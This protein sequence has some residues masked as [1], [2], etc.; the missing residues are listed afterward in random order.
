[1]HRY[2][3]S[4]RLLTALMVLGVLARPMTASAAWGDETSWKSS[5]AN[6]NW[7][8]DHWYNVTQGW[9]NHNPN[10]EGGRD[11]VF[12]N[13]NQL[14]MNN[15]FTGGGASRWRIRFLSGASSGR[16]IG[17]S[18]ANTF[19]DN[20][21]QIPKIENSSAAT[22]T[23]NFPMVVGYSG[24]MEINP[25]SGGLT[26]GGTINNGGYTINVWGDNGH[27]L[28]L[29]NVIS[30]GGKLILKQNSI[31]SINAAQTYT[32]NTEIDKGEIWIG[33][34]GDIASGSAIYVGNGA[35]TAN[36]TK[37]FINNASGGK[38]FARTIN[39][40]A[41]NGT[42]S[43]RE[44][45]ALNSSGVNTF[46][47]NI[48][49]STGADDRTLTLYAPT[50]GTVDFT[51]VISGD[52]RVIKRAAGTVRLANANSYTGNTEIDAGALHI[53]QGGSIAG[54]TVYVGNGGTTGTAA[55]FLI[56]DADGG[57]AVARTIQINPGNGNQG[58]R[59]IGG[60]NT[61]GINTF[62]GAIQRDTDG[63]NE[64]VTLT[65][66]AGGIVEYTGV[67]S[68]DDAVW[69]T[70][71]GITRF[72]GSAKSYTGSTTI[73]GNSTL[74]LNAANLVNDSVNVFIDSGSTFDLNGNNETVNSVSGAGNV[75]LGA[76]QLIVDHATDRTLSGIISGTG[77]FVKKGTS[78]L[79]LSGA[80]TYNGQ[81]YVVGG[82]LRFNVN[83]NA[84]FSNTLNLGET[85]GSESATLALGADGVTLTN[86][87]L[88][89]AGSS[90]V[91]TI[92]ALN[93]TGTAIL[94][95]GIT[96]ANPIT[97]SANAGGALTVS[98]PIANSGNDLTTTTTGSISLNA[99]VGGGGKLIKQGSGTLTLAGANSY[100]GHT[101]IDLGTLVVGSGGDIAD[102]STTYIGNGIS[103][104]N[105]ALELAANGVDL[106][107]TVQVNPDP[108]AG[109]RT[110]ASTAA[111]GGT[112]ISGLVRLSRNVSINANSGSTLTL[113]GGLKMDYSGNNDAT[114]NGNVVLGGAIDVTSGASEINYTGGGTL[115]ISGD[116]SGEPYMLNIAGGTVF[117]NH[118]NALGSATS[119]PDKI[120]FSSGAS[121]LRVGTTITHNSMGMKLA[122]VSPTF[123]VDG[124]ATFTVGGALDKTSGTVVIDK[125][126][127]GDLRL[128]GTPSANN[129]D[130]TVSA[131]T[132]S[133][134]GIGGALTVAGG[135]RIAPGTSPGTMDAGDTAW[136]AGGEYVWE[137]NDFNGAAGS[138]P[139]WD[140]L[141]VTGTLTINATSGNPFVIRLTS[142]N[143][144]V[145]GNAANFN[146]AQPY[147]LTIASAS[148]AVSG[149]VADRFSLDLSGFANAL[150]SGQWS[151]AGSANSVSL[152]FTPTTSTTTTSTTTTSSTTTTTTTTSSSTTT[153]TDSTSTTT[154]STTIDTTTTTTTTTESTSS[155]TTTT[156]TTTTTST[157][158]T[159]TTTTLATTST[160]A[161]PAS[162]LPDVGMRVAQDSGSNYGVAWAGNGGFGFDAW[163][164]ADFQGGGAAGVFLANTGDHGDLNH[165]W[166]TP[167]FKAWGTF[168]NGAGFNAIVA[169][170]SFAGNAL[171]RAGDT[172]KI[173]MENGSIQAG[174]T[175]GIVL[176]HG[177]VAIDYDSFDDQQRLQFY[178][179]GGDSNYKVIDQSGI[180]DTGVPF[181]FDG[182]DLIFKLTGLNTYEL[183]IYYAA[184]GLLQQTLTGTLAGSGTIDSVALFNRDVELANVYF[185]KMTI[186]DVDTL[187]T[188]L[189]FR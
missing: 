98:A 38:T 188:M 24:G 139:G 149:F 156:T 84:N 56:T 112:A 187:P 31:I 120:N 168:A 33:N 147:T 138:D 82:S 37:L 89:R 78:T 124:G 151:V 45:G 141:N 164:F 152:V 159:T 11:L 54:G 163:T 74:R 100:T 178:F 79:T 66:A 95:G 15:D 72:G 18:T 127:A 180:V 92:A 41:G 161:S 61:S 184:S 76:G 63:D 26:L 160:T 153:T 170:R 119:Y 129:V 133:G 55:E 169:F 93:A 32:G 16:T 186:L 1:M 182:V 167:D 134:S 80:N 176:R 142:L 69:V 62:S 174:T 185:N 57:T 146:N 10:Y 30:G 122:G 144:A 39:I 14:S 6:G 8:A 19:Y 171:N 123:Q 179:L 126:G 20:S 60:S 91:K 132:L 94:S 28:T 77:A 83:Q 12:G 131:G 4:G 71:G 114:I 148:T 58:N 113:S 73:G 150:D 115:T 128:T 23:L 53:Q 49:R 130:L 47:G 155:T 86:A 85:G 102:G 117:L 17:G 75:S 177:N 40:N 157:S 166:S 59:V 29:N 96:L 135:A 43:N 34:S 104:G 101:E 175:C 50:G 125:T 143:G 68:G 140:L 35:Q 108:G 70:G 13:N 90:G 51:G 52:D 110:I 165:I 3:Q 181:T 48:V 154:T 9:D 87:I 121:T 99:E 27:T 44:L 172:F 22:H 183:R 111:S 81:T 42:T 65:A 116:N 145:P 97:L 173:S 88:V 105:A 2:L 118:A 5:A 46:S 158:T 67:I 36:T 103:G 162:N 64:A 21:G 136:E 106:G 189:Y 137:I 25:L 107:G 7:N 109:T